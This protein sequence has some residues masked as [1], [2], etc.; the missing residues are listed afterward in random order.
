M[1]KMAWVSGSIRWDGGGKRKEKGGW[2]WDPA[3]PRP[4]ER[5]VEA[6]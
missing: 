2:G 6:V 3:H 1:T 5:E 4:I